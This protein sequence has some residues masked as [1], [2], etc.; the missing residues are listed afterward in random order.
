MIPQG[1]L[2]RMEKMPGI[3]FP[4]FCRA[5]EEPAVRALRLNSLK[6]E[7]PQLLERAGIGLTPLPFSGAAYIIS[8]SSLGAPV[9]G[10][11]GHHPLHH[12]GAF[13]MQDPSAQ[14]TV[15][16]AA[17]VLRPGMRVLDL[18]AAP[19]GKTTQLAAALRHTGELVACEIVPERCRILRQNIERLGVR[20][21]TVLNTDP[22]TVASLYPG[23]FD[24]VLADAPCSGEGMLRKYP[25]AAEEWSAENVAMCAA[26]QREILSRAAD[27]V[28]GGG[29]LLYSTCT[30]SMEENEENILWFLNEHPEFSLLPAAQ[31][32][33][34]V[35]AP[36]VGIPEARR[37][38]PHL[39]PGEGQFLCLMQKE[40]GIAGKPQYKNALRPLTKE[41][42]G[43]AEAFLTDAMG[44]VPGALLMLRDTVMLLSEGIVGCPPGAFCC[45]VAAGEVV[46]GR[47]VP[48]H[49][50]FSAYGD[51]FLRRVDLG[52]DD[53]RCAAYLRG[54]GFTVDAGENGWCAVT[55]GGV[56]LGGGKIV[57]GYVKNHYPKGLRER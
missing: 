42:R 6:C 51:A 12:A 28:A 26:R 41:E 17:H 9:G 56:P 2:K 18:C 4:A 46:K 25:Q 32:V 27:C 13:Y 50:L 39:T 49:H 21:A 7:N 35:T 19:G 48:H 52:W 45:G 15:A 20:G 54:E 53:P 55:V 31:D 30:F 16:A 14:S 22:A 38:Y 8:N 47:L 33:A 10:G 5:M 11:I 40:E 1:F 34:A 43:A 24:F 44:E 3:D 36:G 29:Y 57:N 37:Y 23:Y